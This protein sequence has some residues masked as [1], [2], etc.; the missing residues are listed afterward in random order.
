MTAHYDDHGNL[1]TKTVVI[2]DGSGR[3]IQTKKGITSE[4]QMKTQVSGREFSDAFGR[5]TGKHDIFCENASAPPGDY[6]YHISTLLDTILYD[7]LDRDTEVS[8]PSLGYTTT[9]QYDVMNNASGRRCFTM[10]VTDPNNNTTVQYTD[11]DGRQVQMTDALGG[12]TKMTYDA[13]GQLLSSTD[14]EDFSTTYVYDRLGNLTERVH[15]DAGTTHYAYDAAG[16]M[17][18]ET[19]PLGS[20][21]Y[22]YTYQRLVKKRYSNT[23]ENNV[24]YTYG[25][26]GPNRGRPVSIEDGTGVRVLSYDALGNV[27]NEERTIVLPGTTIAYTFT[28]GYQYDSWGRMLAMT[29]PDG[30]EVTYTYLYGGDLAS[31]CGDKGSAHHDYILGITYNDFGQRSQISYGNGTQADYTYDALHRLSQLISVSPSGTMQKIRYTMDGVGNITKIQNSSTAIGSLG[32]VYT[33]YYYY[34]ALNRLVSSNDSITRYAIDMDY[35][36]SGRLARKTTYASATYPVNTKSFY[37]YCVDNKY[38][39]PKR[40]YE[41]NCQTLTEL[42]WDEAGNLGQIN[43]VKKQEYDDSRFLFWTEDSRL[44]TVADFESHSYY[45]YDHGGERTLKLTGKNTVLDVNAE[46]LVTSSTLD[47]VTLYPSPYVV[48]TN[49]GYT[50]HY[51]VG[52]DRLCA[53]IGGGGIPDI[54]EDND[55]Y[56]VAESLF[57]DCVSQSKDR[58]LYG[59][60]LDCIFGLVGDDEPLRQEISETPTKLDATPKIDLSS[61]KSTMAYCA[62]HN[63]PED[64]VY[65][66]H[67]DHLGSASWISDANGAPVQHLQYLPFGER[68]INQRAAGSTYNERFT[69]TGKEKDSETG[70]CYFGARYYDSDLSG[71]FLSVD[72]M[73]DKYPSLSPY[74]YCAWNPIKIVDPDGRDWYDLYDNG[75]LVRNEKKSKE[76]QNSDVIWSISNKTLSN[77]LSLGTLSEQRRDEKNG[78]TGSYISLRGCR[79]ENVAAFMFCSDNSNVEFSLMEIVSYGDE[80]FTRLTTSHNERRVGVPSTDDY[81]SEYAKSEFFNLVS[82]LHNH[83]SQASPSGDYESGDIS[84]R[85]RINYLR[86][87]SGQTST[88]LWGIY[89]CRGNEKYT[90]D[91]EGNIINPITMRPF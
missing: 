2:T 33:N 67:G 84:F 71:L 40:I 88:V 12:I 52:G 60:D 54:I 87:I 45:A 58:I 91:Y 89:K 61:F 23:V 73:A 57:Q 78:K 77:E 15:P 56:G 69:F 35:S 30:E 39:A 53:R 10:S 59:D 34:D 16:N 68:Y 17:V 7:I 9:K 47:E 50:K 37:G 20:I 11:Y 41:D 70:Y 44:H 86:E 51:Y 1:I 28:T 6:N 46:L 74:A 55:I 29:Y 62:S 83:V 22:D 14:P 64:E 8:Q 19:N 75:T 42:I 26:N 49:K 72:P 24:T 36:A 43:T 90:K 85:N 25:I 31:M 18:S 48:V 76:Y 81:G 32:G 66:Y 82:H 21:F 5:T 79:E 27:T 4:N 3:V 80:T 65:Y 63:D 38:H 13:L